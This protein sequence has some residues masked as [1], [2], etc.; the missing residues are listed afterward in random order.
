M[1]ENKNG[2]LG[3]YG[4]EHSKCNQMMT[5]GFKGLKRYIAVFAKS[6]Q[7]CSV[8]NCLSNGIDILTGDDPVPVKFGPKGTDPQ[9]EG[10]AFYVSHAERCAVGVRT[11]S[12]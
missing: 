4:T 9:Q 10:C 2:G 12:C 1:S 3:P 11:H 5:P 6:R 7:N 8:I